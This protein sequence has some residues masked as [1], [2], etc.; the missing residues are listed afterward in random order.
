VAEFC[1]A[2]VKKVLE[3]IGLNV[4]ESGGNAVLS[5]EIKSF[6][7]IETNVYKA[8][9]SLKVK[10]QDKSGKTLWTG[11]TSGEATR[12]GRSYK[13]ENY[14]EALSDSLTQAVYKL[15][16]A[17]TFRQALISAGS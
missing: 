6:F 14:Y 11:I 8:D 12:F 15:L 17:N 7:V 13:D 16:Q 4:V 5:A 3:Q 10:L 1:R 2:G 9:V